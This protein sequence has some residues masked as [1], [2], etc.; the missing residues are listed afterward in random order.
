MDG[1]KIMNFSI[2]EVSASVA[3]LL[4]RASLSV[5]EVDLF[6]FHQANGYMLEF[7]RRKCGIP[8]HKFFVRCDSVGNTV[9]NTIPI[10][11]HHAMREGRVVPGA[12]VVF[13]GFGVGL[14]WAAC[15]GR[16]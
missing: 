3:A 6:I 8:T 2:R 11:L 15:V 12:T 13:V 10:A 9:S 4:Q 1:T 14:S 5:D 7:L 16:F